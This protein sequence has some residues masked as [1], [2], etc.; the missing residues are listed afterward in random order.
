VL[1]QATADVSVDLQI[2]CCVEFR[3]VDDKASMV[4]P[5]VVFASLAALPCSSRNR[6]PGYQGGVRVASHQVLSR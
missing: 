2:I 6:I 3:F 5:V 4:L 1:N